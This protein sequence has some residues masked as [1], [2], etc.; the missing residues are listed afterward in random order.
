MLHQNTNVNLT[1]IWD[2]K[3]YYEYLIYISLNFTVIK[4]NSKWVSSSTLPFYVF[5]SM[6]KIVQ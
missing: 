2:A 3:Y 4:R 6:V 1:F 5:L